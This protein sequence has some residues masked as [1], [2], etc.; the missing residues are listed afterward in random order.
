[1]I[2]LCT[3]FSHDEV[4]FLP[5]WHLRD[6][7][8]VLPTDFASEEHGKFQVKGTRDR[9][10]IEVPPPRG[11]N[12]IAGNHRRENLNPGGAARRYYY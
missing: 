10:H 7:T 11:D 8:W 1:M 6:L 12:H 5:P 2:Y 3:C 4:P 9:P